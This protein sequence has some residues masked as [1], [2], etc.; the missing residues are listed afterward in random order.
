MEGQGDHRLHCGQIH[1]YHAVVVGHICRI[2]LPVVFR[3]AVGRQKRLRI[4]VCSPDGSPAGGLCGH[5][6]DAVSEIRGHSGDPRSYKFH[7]FV[8]HITALE[9]LSDNGQRDILRT[10]SRVHLSV[11]IHAYDS[12]KCHVIGVSQQLLHQFPAAFSYCH[13]SQSAVPCMA[14]GTQDHPAASGHGLTHIL[15]DYRD[16]GRNVDSAILF[17]GRQAEHVIVLIDGSSYRTQGIVAVGQHIGN[18]KLRHAGSPGC[19]DN[20]YKGNVMR[21][22]GIESEPEI[23]HI[24]RGIMCLDDLISHCSL[25]GLSLVPIPSCKCL[26]FCCFFL[27]YDL[28]SVDQIHS[29]VIQLNHVNPSILCIFITLLCFSVVIIIPLCYNIVKYYFCN[30]SHRFIL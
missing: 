19:L 28:C 20:S 26:Y 6:I 29:A 1:I 23:F 5:N 30:I 7:D 16:V 4:P 12:R 27:R 9:H 18:R 17:A 14:V 8:L 22:K 15:M 25:S 2:Q 21:S 13:G 10:Y 11:Q 3:S 24:V